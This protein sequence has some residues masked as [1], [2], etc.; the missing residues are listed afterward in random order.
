MYI[1]NNLQEI[2]KRSMIKMENLEN[3]W[4]ETENQENMMKMDC[5]SESTQSTPNG[6]GGDLD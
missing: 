3:S 2:G 5:I 1:S 6:E 4:A